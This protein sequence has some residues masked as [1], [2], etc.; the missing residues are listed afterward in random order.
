MDYSNQQA[1][2][3]FGDLLTVCD[4]AGYYGL[5]SIA[6]AAGSNFWASAGN[7]IAVQG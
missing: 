6:I 5:G 7:C 1:E 3:A 2:E 4:A